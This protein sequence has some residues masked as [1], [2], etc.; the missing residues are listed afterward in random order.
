MAPV[1]HL[2][3]ILMAA[4]VAATLAG[5]LLSARRGGP[6]G[7][8]RAA[9]AIAAVAC[10]AAAG[11]LVQLPRLVPERQA[12]T[13]GTSEPVEAD[14]L[15][16]LPQFARTPDGL[17][18]RAHVPAGAEAL[19]GTWPLLAYG[20]YRGDTGWRVDTA[21][22]SLPAAGVGVRVDVS[23]AHGERLL[24]HPYG[25]TSGRPGPLRYD[26]RAQALRSAEPSTAYTL[27]AE[28]APRT[29]DGL[30]VRVAPRTACAGPEVA[31]LLAR[32]DRGAPLAGQ[33]AQLERELADTGGTDP[34]GAVDD[35][36]EAVGRALGDG[37]GTSD[38]Y[39]TAFAL[40]ARMLGASSRVVAGFAPQRPVAADGTVE[41]IGADAVAW[42]QIAYEGG[43]WVDYWPL[44]GRAAVGGG[45]PAPGAGGA[46]RP[47]GDEEPAVPT[48]ARHRAVWPFALGGAAGLALSGAATA[49]AVRARRRR[50]A[51]RA[52]QAWWEARSPRERVLALWQRA[53]RDGAV[54]PGA[55]ARAVAASS[56]SPPL[57]ALAGLVN[58][59]LYAPDFAP[60]PEQT[61]RASALADAVRAQSAAPGRH[62]RG[63]AEELAELHAAARTPD[64]PVPA[65]PRRRGSGREAGGH[66]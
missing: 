61:A 6:A 1:R 27:T 42:P 4:V 9:A 50:A 2:V 48:G 59:T 5:V 31:G 46:V 26:A 64:P 15:A 12:V 30:P 24:P 16:R 41:V 13:P 53:L 19:A 54:A 10:V 47:P 8:G 25:V 7:R 20:T 60:G 21:L 34:A 66:V 51:R 39:A 65:A 14:P 28:P 3:E 44:P 37:H 56:G 62:R 36:C 58:D 33:L 22:T 45:G 57:R 35:S 18:L 43:T 23:L 40:A 55:T 29:R 63:P 38:Q 17:V 32:V 49:A 11:A 52:A